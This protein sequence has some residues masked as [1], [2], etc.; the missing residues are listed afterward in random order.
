MMLISGTV[1]GKIENTVFITVTKMV[2]YLQS[3]YA[4]KDTCIVYS[5]F[6]IVQNT[7]YIS[8]DPSVHNTVCRTLL[9][10]HMYT[11]YSTL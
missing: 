7:L 1:L 4:F 11:T 6:D 5:V 8:A 9:F 3:V 10:I 2:I